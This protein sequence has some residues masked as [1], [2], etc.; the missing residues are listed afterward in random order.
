MFRNLK[1]HEAVVDFLRDT[2][3]ILNEV[4]DAATDPKIIYYFESLFLFLRKF[5]HKN[6]RNQQLLSL[7]IS[8]FI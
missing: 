4:Y 3:Y 7:E 2:F 1:A 5:C 8:I 6:A